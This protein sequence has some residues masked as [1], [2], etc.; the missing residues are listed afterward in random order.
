VT[1]CGQCRFENR[2]IN[3]SIIPPAGG[4]LIVMPDGSLRL[5]VRGTV[6]T[7]DGELIFYETGGV[8]V[9]GQGAMDRFNK[10]EVI[11]STDEYFI[12]TTRFTTASKKY[13]WLNHIQAVGKMVSMQTTRVK[14]DIFAVR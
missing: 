8:I 3:G 14:Y 1:R 13:A 11:T 12:T 5:D 4:W 9:P 6:K 10:G 7:D 2:Q